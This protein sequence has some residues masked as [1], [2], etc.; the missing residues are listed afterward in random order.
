[1]ALTKQQNSVITHSEAEAITTSAAGVPIRY[2]Q[3]WLASLLR[4]TLIALMV[5]CVDWVF[6]A[7]VARIAPFLATTYIPA[8]VLL[9]VGAAILGCITTTVLAQPHGRQR[10]TFGYR[11]AELGLLLALTRVVIWAVTGLWPSPLLLLTAPLTTLLDGP[12]I[13]GLFVVML[14]WLMATSAT[15]D[16]LRMALQ[17]DE[18]YAIESDRIGE[19]VRTST[20]D[21][22]A[23]LRGLVTRWVIGGILLVVF[24]AG[25]GL[26]F[27]AGR[28]FFTLTP[29]AAIGPSIVAAVIL[30]FLSGLVLISHGQLAILRSR[31][32]IDR[33]PSAAS[34]LRNW[35][36]YSLLLLGGIGLFAALLPF[37]S[38][39]YLA[40]VLGWLVTTVFNLVAG[41]FRFLMTLL[42]LI[43]SLFTGEPPPP[44]EEP[45]APPP[46]PITPEIP[47]ATNQ[48]PE[49]AGGA[50]FWIG[51]AL[52]LGYA[53]Y[54][55]FQGRG[56]NFG[57]LKRLWQMLRARWQSWRGAYQTWLESRIPALA[58][59]E[60]EAG[61]KKKR[62]PLSQWRL[63]DLDP[64]Q[65]VRYFYLTVVEQ[66][67]QS[68]TPRRASETP[69]QY[70][71]RLAEQFTE[72]PE[73]AE[74]VKMLTEAFVQIRYSKQDVDSA[75]LSTLQQVW[76]KIRQHLQV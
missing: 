44:V 29:S 43:A 74:A 61:G 60:G 58:T 76:Q 65:R 32:T 24:A 18:L 3:P 4:P 70:A 25:L 59:P 63:G 16:L 33:V 72:D 67:S 40:Q 2:D 35:P 5:A 42:L 14:S 47:P 50:F 26:D 39:F 7:F 10:R 20:S 12:F 21:R 48:F 46:A 37:G 45:P 52:L 15:E 31:W 36:L 22:P 56:F 62:R 23:L 53:A 34:I 73:D 66:A 55:Y 64:A 17:P 71:P 1:M 13:V 27:T 75:E 49:W 30:Y 69:R 28:S 41:L 11:V 38:T 6:L 54:I 8:M 9:S 19:L 68:K 51:M 57:W